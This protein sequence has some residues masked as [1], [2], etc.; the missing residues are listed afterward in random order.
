MLWL[1]RQIVSPMRLVFPVLW[2]FHDRDFENND[3][4]QPA[5]EGDL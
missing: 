3:L 1:S 5:F 2:S 4:E